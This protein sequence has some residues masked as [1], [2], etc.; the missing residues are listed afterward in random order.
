M[1]QTQK[2]LKVLMQVGDRGLSGTEAADML[3][4]RDLPKRI[5]ELRHYGFEIQKSV[6]R[7]VFGQRYTRYS[8][9]AFEHAYA[10][11]YLALANAKDAA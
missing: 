4:V 7:D 9:P 8:L 11:H 3:R 2:V 5:S 1:N 6:R 10:R